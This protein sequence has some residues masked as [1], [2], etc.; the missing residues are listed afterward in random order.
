MK[1]L[2]HKSAYLLVVACAIASVV[3]CTKDDTEP[4]LPNDGRPSDV[5]SF[6]AALADNHEPCIS[7]GTSGLLSIEQE[8]WSL[9]VVG[10]KKSGTRGMPVSLLSDLGSAGV[11][12]Y[13]YNDWETDNPAPLDI[14]YNKKYLF[15]GDHMTAADDADV[16]WNLLES[17]SNA[18]FYVYAPYNLSGAILSDKVAA[19]APTLTYTVPS[20]VTEQQDLIVAS[21]SGASNYKKSIPLMFDHALTGVKFNVGFDCTVKKLEIKNIPNKGTYTF[22]GEW[23]PATSSTS[24][25]TFD[26]GSGQSFSKDGVLTSDKNTLL[27]IPQTFP[28][29]STAEVVLTYADDTK[30]IIPLKGKVWEPGKMITYTIHKTEAPE[31][32]YFDLAADSILIGKKA[33]QGDVEKYGGNYGIAEGDTIYVGKIYVDDV[34]TPVVGKHNKDNTYY[35][36]QSSDTKTGCK[37][38]ET[39]YETVEKFNS[40]IDCR[41]PQYEPVTYKVNGVERLWSDFITNNNDVNT[42]IK[43]WYE[44]MDQKTDADKRAD[45]KGRKGTKHWIKVYPIANTDFNLVIDNIYSTF[46][47]QSTGRTSGGI[48]FQPSFKNGDEIDAVANS[49][50]TITTLGDNRLGNI[51]YANAVDKGSELIFEG[52]G[53]L[54]VAD[55]IPKQGHAPGWGTEGFFA[56][57]YCSVIGGNDNGKLTEWC[58]G[59]IINSGVL[60]AGSTA[61]ENC[62]AIGGGGNG[63]GDVTINGGTVTAVAAT[64]GTAIGGGIGYSSNGGQGYVHINGGNVYAYNMDNMRGIPSS[65]IG[66]AGSSQS[67]GNIGE[68]YITGGFVYAYSALGTAIGG[69]SSQTKKGGDA[70]INISGG[71]VIAKSGRGA[72]IG[73]GSACTGGGSGEING[74]TATVTI[75]GN[76]IIRTGSIGGG[77]TNADNGYIGSAKINISGTPD[78]QAQFVMASGTE[79]GKEPEFVMSGGTIRNSYVD[80]PEYKHIKTYGGAVYL[81]DGTFKMT[82]GTIKNCSAEQGGAVYIERKSDT[83]M[84]PDK[85]NFVISDEAKIHSCFTTGKKDSSG[86]VWEKGHGG[87]LCLNGGQVKMEGGEIYNNYSENGNGGGIYISNGNF[88]MQQGTYTPSIHK[89]SAQKGDGGGV[90]ITSASD[91]TTPLSVQLLQGYVLGNSANSFGGG[92]CV[93]MSGSDNGAN[94]VVGVDGQSVEKETANPKIADNIALRAGGGLYVKGEEAIITINS[95]MIDENEVSAYVKNEDVTN[96][97]GE[98]VLNKGLVDHKLVTFVGNG[99]QTP[100]PESQT[101]YTQNIVTNTNSKLA[102]NKFERAGYKFSHWN[103]RA[104]GLGKDNY[105]ERAFIDASENVTLYAQWTAM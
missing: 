10:D 94:I 56:N 14:L 44:E 63:L 81:E 98:V 8:D 42:I 35:V 7:R 49:K 47:T 46:Q 11:I 29:S 24:N 43:A 58:Y 59:I 23:E 13:A 83:P 100:A 12:G 64:T 4:I 16:R 62:S 74:G 82:G 78:I 89:N 102:A 27:M 77:M 32:I 88:V 68:V 51:H 38:S 22:G 40:K 20:N 52:T 9:Q 105:N 61:S 97:G 25:Y 95:G 53:S 37:P 31:T 104:D 99:G 65:A 79:A 3:G 34:A 86:N 36:Y 57:Y 72:G 87:A 76:P 39:G 6:T 80:D 85:F 91:N 33:T 75:T 84:D 93:D 15:D 103:T 55:V 5:V 96:K 30:T 54:T 71:Q 19:G 48:A 66:G 1:R 17:N 60:F 101:S 70:E 45:L 18:R 92:I 90:Y 50:L 69:G 21:W 41:V 26:F 67:T 28:E 73:G 2:N